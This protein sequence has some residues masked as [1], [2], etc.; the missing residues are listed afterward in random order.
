M[1]EL[2]G[3]KTILMFNRL[4]EAALAEVAAALKSRTLAAGEVLFAMGDPG[5]ELFIVKTGRVAIYAP[6]PD[7]PGDERPI[8]IFEAGEAL[9]EMALID[10]QPRSL[11]AR[12]LEPAEVLILTGDDFRRLLR[13][14]P[15]M[16]LA[17]MAGLN[18][19]IRYTTDFLSEV[20]GWIQR[21]AAGQYDRSFAASKDYQDSSIESLA[22]EFA[23]MAAQVQQREEELRKE[24]LE[25]RIEINEAKRQKQLEEITETDYFQTLQSKAKTLR[26]REK[27]RQVSE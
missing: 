10:N 19:R 4:P 1:T 11:S 14:Y 18:D 22:A 16:A 27:N 17:V 7:K 3:L 21:V 15:D 9:G 8:R 6:D 25:L 20:R 5:D 12:A 13:T 24:V 26:Q 23:Q 2:T